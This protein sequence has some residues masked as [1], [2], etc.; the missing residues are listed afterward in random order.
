MMVAAGMV[1]L[2]TGCATKA[3]YKEYGNLYAQGQYQAAS[4]LM[5]AEIGD[6]PE[7][8]EENI[9]KGKYYLETLD[10]ASAELANGNYEES[11]AMFENA[12]KSLSERQDASAVGKGASQV[13]ATLSNDNSLPYPIRDYDQL[14]MGSLKTVATLGAN[15]GEEA[16]TEI[17]RLNER[18]RLIVEEN[19]KAILKKQDAA[20]EAD[21]A[22][23]AEANGEGENAEDGAEASERNELAKKSVLEAF[24]NEENKAK[25]DAYKAEASQWEPYADYVSPYVPYL[26]GLVYLLAGETPSDYES[27]ATAFRKCYG[28]SGASVVSNALSLAEK[29]DARN[30]KVFVI[31]E[32]GLAPEKDENNLDFVIPVTHKGSV[33]MLYAGLSLPKLTERPAAYSAF[34]IYSN[35]GMVGKTE[36]ICSLDRVIGGEFKRE[37]PGIIVRNA[38]SAGIKTTINGLISAAISEKNQ[39]LG[40]LASIGMSALQKGTTHADTRIWNSLPKNIQAAIVDKPADGKLSFCVEGT[41]TSMLDVVITQP[42]PAFVFIRVPTAGVVPA[43]F[44]FPSE[45]VVSEPVAGSESVEQ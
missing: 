10:I 21:S 11:I 36:E 33:L 16:V 17:L 45:T 24:E 44:V 37:L 6:T 29:P 31:F 27:A 41:T 12:E 39:G 1:S 32:N 38:I 19:E 22:L 43:C 25:L 35:G 4:A 20:A 26:E 18:A 9:G 30:E 2:L 40:M 42:G 8:F 7:E 15:K 23:A 34:D 14:M 28:M 3:V 13:G 5:R